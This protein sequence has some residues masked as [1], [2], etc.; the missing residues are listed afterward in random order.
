ML[1]V[2]ARLPWTGGRGAWPG[3]AGVGQASGE[4]TAVAILSG[5]AFRPGRLTA[6]DAAAVRRRS[7]KADAELGRRF[8]WAGVAQ[9]D[10]GC[11]S[12]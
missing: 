8:K 12:A 11:A 6:E 3:S 7:D 10:N 5:E 2:V 1:S 4:E 9:M